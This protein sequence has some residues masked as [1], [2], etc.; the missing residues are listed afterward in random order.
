M[1][2]VR[3][4]MALGF[5]WVLVSSVSIAQEQQPGPEHALL[6]RWVG[7]WDATIKMQGMES[8]GTA[9]YR[10]Q[11]GGFWLLSHFKGDFGGMKF[12][13]NGMTGYDPNKKKYVD[14]WGDSMA[15][16][17]VVEEGTYDNEGKVL[18]LT[19]E[20]PGPGG[21]TVKYKTTTE[22]KDDDTMLWTLTT[23]GGEGKYQTIMTITYK[24]QK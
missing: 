9:V 19:G 24:R 4:V 15:A 22:M 6:K 20:G 3:F 1:N 17:P 23:P 8:K 7:T 16:G 21:K 10:L 2:K 18:T 12:E 14:F 13:G 11:E 5:A